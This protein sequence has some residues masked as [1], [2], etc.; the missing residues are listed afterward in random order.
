[1]DIG[2]GK[3]AAHFIHRTPTASPMTSS[4]VVMDASVGGRWRKS[5]SAQAWAVLINIVIENSNKILV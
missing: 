1:V 3:K 4:P 2:W 5:G